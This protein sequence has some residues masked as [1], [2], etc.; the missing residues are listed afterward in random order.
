MVVLTESQ[1]RVG[2]K[3]N[4]PGGDSAAV[5]PDPMPNSAVKRRSADG[6]VGSPHVR[7]G[8]CQALLLVLCCDERQHKAQIAVSRTNLLQMDLSVA[9]SDGPKG[10]W[11]ASYSVNCQS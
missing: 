2:I 8:H 5:P 11:Q 4:M 7:V 6:S 3:R 9:R 1:T 10:E